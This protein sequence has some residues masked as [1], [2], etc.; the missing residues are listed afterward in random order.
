VGRPEK[1][2][3]VGF[4]EAY[5]GDT[6]GAMSVGRTAAFHRPYFPLLFKVHYAP[7][8]FAYRPP[9]GL[10]GASTEA[11]GEFCLKRLESIL[12]EHHDRIAAVAI[13]P[14]V[15]GAAGMIVQPP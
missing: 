11:V 1:N 7:T 6:D 15:Q 13:E 3:F 14:I 8:P 9:E 2:E 4:A 5:H 12:A 10:A